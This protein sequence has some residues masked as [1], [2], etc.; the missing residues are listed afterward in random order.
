[1]HTNTNNAMSPAEL[2]EW[3]RDAVAYSP[4]TEPGHGPWRIGS[5]AG[6]RLAVCP[7]CQRR[8]FARGLIGGHH[9]ATWENANPKL[10][11]GRQCAG[12][13]NAW[14]DLQGEDAS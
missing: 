4:R 5:L 1:M 14:A 9:A 7:T 3:I 10:D 12:G 6:Q 2:C 11:H 8:M 13:C